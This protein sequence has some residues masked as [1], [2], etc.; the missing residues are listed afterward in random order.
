[1]GDVVAEFPTVLDEPRV[2]LSVAQGTVCARYLELK[3]LPLPGCVR[4]S[5]VVRALEHG[6]AGM[7]KTL[8]FTEGE[9]WLWATEFENVHET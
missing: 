8:E 9:P 6:T 7:A 4:L 3:D 5:L 2:Y 1:M